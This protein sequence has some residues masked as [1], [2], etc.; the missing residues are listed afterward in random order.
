MLIF[1]EG[2]FAV[3]SKHV[4]FYDTIANKLQDSDAPNLNL[5]KNELEIRRT[6]LR[7]KGL[8]EIQQAAIQQRDCMINPPIDVVFLESYKNFLVLTKDSLRVYNGKNGRLRMYLDSI[9]EKDE[10]TQS[11]SELTSMCLNSEHR[12]VYVGDIHGGIKCYNV[13]TGLLIKKMKLD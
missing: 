2:K 10:R 3:L 5:K 4:T 11:L 6:I 1:S 13:N 7:E 12:M 8:S 9:V